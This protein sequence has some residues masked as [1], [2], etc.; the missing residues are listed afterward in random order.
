VTS[1][2]AAVQIGP[3]VIVHLKTYVPG[4]NPVIVVLF[5]IGE[6]IVAVL[7]PEI[8]DQFPIP[9]TGAVA[10]MV[11]VVEQ[12]GSWSGPAFAEEGGA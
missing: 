2:Y 6:V 11:A 8:C 10:A 5:K 7:G 3:F 1:S 12:T 4:I 9:M